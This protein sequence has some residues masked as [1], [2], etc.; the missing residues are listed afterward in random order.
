[1]C[2]CVREREREKHQG[3]FTTF[4]LKGKK[5][6][7]VCPKEQAQLEEQRDRQERSSRGDPGPSPNYLGNRQL[8]MVTAFGRGVI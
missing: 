1:M 6:G 4:P 2:V 5:M 7:S 3:C 8:P